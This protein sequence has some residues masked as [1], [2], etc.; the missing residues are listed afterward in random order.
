MPGEPNLI[1]TYL[2]ERRSRVRRLAHW[3]WV[4]LLETC[5]LGSAVVL[6]GSQ[7]SDPAAETREAIQGTVG[8]IDV[9]S[10]AV[11]DSQAELQQLQ[12]Q[13]AVAREVVRKPDWSILLAALSW[14]SQGRV[15]FESLQMRGVS[16][17]DGGGREAYVLSIYGTCAGRGAL[18]EF[19]HLLESTEL[20]ARVKITQT[21]SV[22]NPDDEKNPRVGFTVDARIEEGR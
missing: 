15:V 2:L 3:K 7:V 17:A 13:L 11:A 8:Q 19:V 1:P 20:F 16:S 9:V 21:Q 10:A 5:L 6:L 22:P 12:Q 4:L 18:T 14:E